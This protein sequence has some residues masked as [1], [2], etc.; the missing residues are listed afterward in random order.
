M[1]GKCES[2]YQSCSFKRQK[3]KSGFARRK[4][5]KSNG[6]PQSQTC[7]K[8]SLNNVVSKNWL[9]G[10]GTGT[11]TGTYIDNFK[12][13]IHFSV[14]WFSRDTDDLQEETIKSKGN[15]LSIKDMCTSPIS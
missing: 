3:T 9:T 7:S 4:Y 14:I 6:F 8:H 11:G 1:E 15:N 2:P 5:L 13:Y 12:S 10:T